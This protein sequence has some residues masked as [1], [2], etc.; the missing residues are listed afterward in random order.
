MK[1]FMVTNKMTN[2]LTI[3]K[4]A[5]IQEVIDINGEGCMIYFYG[6]RRSPLVVKEAIDDIMDWMEE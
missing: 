5:D 4:S 6:V 3:I 1:H 2:R